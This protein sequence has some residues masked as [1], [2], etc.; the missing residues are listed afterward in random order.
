MGQKKLRY[1]YDRE[2]D[3]TDFYFERPRKAKTV[4]LNEDFLLRLDSVTEEVAGPTVI[5]F[6]RH[7]SFFLSCREKFLTTAKW[8]RAPYSKPYWRPDE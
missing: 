6:S 7:F 5:G 2:A 4:E 3:A 1:H 8:K